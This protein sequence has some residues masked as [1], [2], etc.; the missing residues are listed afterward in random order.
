MSQSIKV[1]GISGS[2]RADS[3]NTGA[4]R[5]AQ[6]LVPVGM[7]ITIADLSD[8]PHYDQDMQSQGV[9]EAVQTLSE[10]IT[11]ADALLFA[12]PEYNHS[13][14]GVLKNAIDWVSRLNPQP[15]ADKPAAL[16]SAAMGMSGG[17]LGQYALRQ[18]VVYL[19]VHF[20]NKPEVMIP[21]AHKLFDEHG[22]LN[23]ERTRQHIAKL[24][25]ALA[26]WTQRLR[27]DQETD[28]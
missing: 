17:A 23:D 2:L 5:A 11:Q 20:L 4:L 28:T 3:Y 8:I 12:T 21:S 6:E 15:M 27:V 7:Q 24:L 14:P 25:I 18:T 1:L 22:N 19:D 10:Q 16:M 9:P 26:D 13:I